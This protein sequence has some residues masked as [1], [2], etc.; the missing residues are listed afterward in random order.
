MQLM[1]RLQ[2]SSL[3]FFFSSYLSFIKIF[4]LILIYFI[5]KISIK[6]GFG[7]GLTS[8]IITT[9]GL[10][11][12]LNAGTH[13]RMVVIGGIFIIAIAD[14][15]SDGFGMHISEE[16]TH[17]KETKATWESTFSTFFF[18]LIFAL[19]FVIPVLFLELNTAIIASIIWGF[20]LLTAFSFH[21][22]RR[23]KEKPI[24]V[25]GQHLIIAIMV[26]IATHFIGMWIAKVFV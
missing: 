4:K 18:K 10:I 26:V 7:F 23:N 11:V 17:K 16:S 13:S 6:K 24:R 14:A 19:S 25:I 9:L 3:F 8:G 22:A 15:L 21:I 2:L 20:F 5:M 12:G 1:K